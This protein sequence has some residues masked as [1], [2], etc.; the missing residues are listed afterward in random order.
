MNVFDCPRPVIYKGRDKKQVCSSCGIK[1]SDTTTQ[2]NQGCKNDDTSAISEQRNLFRSRCF[3]LC[4]R[5]NIDRYVKPIIYRNWKLSFTVGRVMSLYPWGPCPFKNIIA[6]QH[7]NFKSLVRLY[8]M[9]V[10]SN[11][12]YVAKLL[13]L[14]RKSYNYP[15]T[16]VMI[17]Y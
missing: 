3:L 9:P 8:P 2:N 12:D 14:T 7:F 5:M 13:D 10:Y 4:G 16:S 1:L 6:N 17:T 11:M 15:G